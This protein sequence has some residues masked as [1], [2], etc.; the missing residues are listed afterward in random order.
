MMIMKEPII[1]TRLNIFVRTRGEFKII[2]ENF[3]ESFGEFVN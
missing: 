3:Q 1:F 2:A